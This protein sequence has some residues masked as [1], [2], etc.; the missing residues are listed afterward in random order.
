MRKTVAALA[1]AAQALV[2]CGSAPSPGFAGYRWQ[3]VAIS[4]AG[5]TTGIPATMRVGLQFS[6]D[7][8]FGASDGVNFYSG[9]Y[10]TIPGNG[11][12]TSSMSGTLV[13]YA[14]HDSAVLLAISAIQ[15]FSD[16]TRATYRLT[17][18]RLTVTV[19][20]YTLTTQR[21]GTS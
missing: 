4:H 6:T 9:S 11:F 3:V 16:G 21:H 14:G 5:K 18:D 2:A 15:S 10:S 8:R 13:G 17:G 20:S 7:G 12:T 19:G 1:V